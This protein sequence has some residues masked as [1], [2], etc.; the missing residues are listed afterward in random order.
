LA[1]LGW[2][3]VG[4]L[5]VV[6][7]VAVGTWTPK[8]AL[9]LTLVGPGLVSLVDQAIRRDGAA[10]AGLALLGV[11]AVS[12]LLAH[13][14]V[15]AAVGP[16]LFG[17]GLWFLA[18]VAGAWS[19]GR[20]LLT[21]YGAV[22]GAVLI[23]VAVLNVV[24]AVLEHILG[25]RS[26]VFSHSSGRPPGLLGNPVHLG[27][28]AAAAFSLV[29]GWVASR[30]TGVRGRALLATVGL[31]T[32]LAVGVQLSGSRIALMAIVVA[33]ALAAV[34]STGADRFLAGVALVAG[35]SVAG[36]LPAGG[37]ESL[38]G[39]QRV[40]LTSEAFGARL[41]AWRSG[42][43]AVAERPLLGWGPGGFL[44][45][46]SDSR[47]RRIVAANGSDGYYLDAHN[48]VVETGVTLGLLG[49]SM[50]VAWWILAVRGASGPLVWLAAAIG[51]CALFQPQHVYLVPVA[52]LAFGAA[53]RSPPATAA[54][55]IRA[56]WLVVGAF[57]LLAGLFVAG[58]FVSGQWQVRRAYDRRDPHLLAIAERRLPWPEI[59][60]LRWQ[61]AGRRGLGG[62]TAAQREAI[63]AAEEAI[64]RDPRYPP[65]WNALG[66]AELDFGDPARARRAYRQALRLDPWSLRAM[67]GLERLAAA[68]GDRAEVRRW[69][70]R[71]CRIGPP[72]CRLARELA[73]PPARRPVRS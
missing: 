48:A 59:S 41:D 67:L 24:V 26:Y 69:Q 9:A 42:M 71:A 5:V 54:P 52:A 53:G 12:T 72:A 4:G 45:A 25:A 19:L 7:Q 22:L 64:R 33:A 68:D 44:A 34:R 16:Y 32:V 31:L 57:G 13:R 35:L 2:V 51:A 27:A 47:T 3:L 1:L 55:P 30:A 70:R 10:C 8:V 6:P 39:T 56:V 66:T 60:L 37:D 21:R 11:G 29:A 36:G 61:F 38:T 49:L 20:R 28:F 62:D 63:A 46:T 65:A 50:W 40:G 58:V 14:P 15:L 18:A 23:L 17:T 73:R 43:Q